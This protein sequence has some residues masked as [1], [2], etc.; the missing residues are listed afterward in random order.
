MNL[1]RGCRPVTLAASP[2]R[3]SRTP[4]PQSPIRHVLA[5]RRAAARQPIRPRPGLTWTLPPN[6]SVVL[7]PPPRRMAA[8]GVMDQSRSVTG[9][10]LHGAP[11]LPRPADLPPSVRR[12]EPADAPSGGVLSGFREAPPP[13]PAAPDR[14]L[15]GSEGNPLGYSPGFPIS[16][17][18]SYCQ[19]IL[20]IP[21]D[22]GWQRRAALKKDHC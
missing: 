1:R 2:P 16:P 7:I 11:A 10:D 19:N 13:T 3:R 8:W 20:P 22:S 21:P 17:R 15:N 9:G 12:S 5:P 14:R 4:R 18:Q 6:V